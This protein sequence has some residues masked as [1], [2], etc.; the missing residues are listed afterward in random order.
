M[1]NRILFWIFAPLK[2]I[3][4]GV[5]IFLIFHAFEKTSNNQIIGLDTKILLSILF[6]LL[7]LIIEYIFFE[8]T[9]PRG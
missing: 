4:L 7:T 2:N 9:R 5:I 3:S 8:S 1:K 6:P